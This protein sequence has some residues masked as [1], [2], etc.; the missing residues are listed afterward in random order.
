MQILIFFIF[1]L[2]IVIALL[3]VALWRVSREEKA[4]KTVTH[5]DRIVSLFETDA[6]L[7]NTEIRKAMG[8]SARTVVR[9]M[10]ELEK[11]GLVVQT[12]QGGPLT[13]YILKK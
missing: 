12:R 13:T 9:Y 5:L 11:A 4:V 3:T 2:L 8:V 10:D 1:I 6:E 7:T